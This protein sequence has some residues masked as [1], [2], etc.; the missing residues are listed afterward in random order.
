[1]DTRTPETGDEA[2]LRRLL[3]YA[4]QPVRAMA[5]PESDK[6]ASMDNNEEQYEAARAA[7]KP[8]A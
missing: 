4:I 2:D 7:A 8:A 5:L 3:E 1:M 6:R